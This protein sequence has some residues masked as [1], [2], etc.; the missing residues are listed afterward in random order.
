MKARGRPGIEHKT[1]RWA[2]PL[3]LVSCMRCL[4]NIFACYMYTFGF[5]LSYIIAMISM[6][7]GTATI[8]VAAVTVLE[9]TLDRPSSNLDCSEQVH[10]TIIV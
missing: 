10:T 4:T 8:A 3:T 9:F 5:N 2:A 1:P 6:N 7:F